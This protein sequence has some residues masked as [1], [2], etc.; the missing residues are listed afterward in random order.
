MEKTQF[1]FARQGD[2][3]LILDFIRRLAVYEKMEEDV[4]AT[5]AL[6]RE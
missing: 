3:G 4:V 1:R 6:L 2:E 5:E